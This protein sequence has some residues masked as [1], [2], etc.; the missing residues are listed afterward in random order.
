MD[1]KQAEIIQT[2]HV[3]PEIDP[4]SEIR[5]RVQFMKDYC[6]QAR[7]KGFVLGISGGQDSTLAGRLAQMA[8]EELRAEGCSAQFIA[9]RMPYGMQKDEADAQAAI[10]FIQ[11]DRTVTCN[12]KETVDA[13]TRTHAAAFKQE[14]A[15]FHK[16]NVKARIRMTVQ[17]AIAGEYGLLVVGTD[18]AAEAA[19]GFFTK[20]GDGGADLLPLSGLTKRQVRQL[21]I[22]LNAPEPLY[23]KV[24]TADL[25]DEKPLQPDETDLG[26]SY[27]VIDDFLEGKPVDGA[28]KRKLI[29]RYETSR[30]KRK[31]PAGPHDHWW[32]K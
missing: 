5:M 19:T 9:V 11:P 10:A 4:A 21:L 13:L 6:K 7:A 29:Q 27:D 1:L 26:F 28:A 25:L 31:L 16:G 15:D 2:L 12:I 30:H 18:N 3:K 22:A 20:H 17:Y 8:A 32:K 24:P 14:L 23:L